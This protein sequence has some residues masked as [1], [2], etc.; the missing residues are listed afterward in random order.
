MTKVKA[1][2][3]SFLLLA[4]A[5]LLSGM[6]AVWRKR[7]TWTTDNP[8]PH[9]LDLVIA[10]H[11]AGLQFS[12]EAL[13]KFQQALDARQAPTMA[14]RNLAELLLLSSDFFL[15]A[16]DTRR[17]IQFVTLYDPYLS[18]CVSPF[19]LETSVRARR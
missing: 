8:S 5:A 16:E 7:P 4:A 6:V 19:P 1:A 10:Q 18:P 14:G 11:L 9:L 3:R 13:D 2:R 15:Y 17:K 12:R